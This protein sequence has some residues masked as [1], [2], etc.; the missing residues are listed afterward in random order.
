MITTVEK[1]SQ[2]EIMSWHSIS[3]CKFLGNLL[4]YYDDV[5]HKKLGRQ[6]WNMLNIGLT[7]VL[8]ISRA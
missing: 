5:T 2:F 6:L 1:W 7:K 3:V 4:H 8:I